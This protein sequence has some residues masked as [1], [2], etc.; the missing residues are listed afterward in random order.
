MDNDF[1]TLDGQPVQNASVIRYLSSLLN[2]RGRRGQQVRLQYIKGHSGDPGN[3]GADAQANIGATLPPRPELD[4]SAMQSRANDLIESLIP[5][6]TSEVSVSSTVEAQLELSE[7]SERPKKMPKNHAI[8]TQN[9]PIASHIPTHIS[10]PVAQVTPILPNRSPLRSIKI[11]DSSLDRPTIYSR[12]PHP[13]LSTPES[14]AVPVM[15]PPMLESSFLAQSPSTPVRRS[16]ETP[17]VTRTP[18]SAK[19]Y[20]QNNHTRTSEV[21]RLPP[22]PKSPLKVSQVAP[23]LIPVSMSDVDLDV[24]SISC[25][26]ALEPLLK[27]GSTSCIG[28]AY[29]KAKIGSERLNRYSHFYNINSLFFCI[30]NLLMDLVT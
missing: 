30:Y 2:E 10:V 19:T 9:S 28:I 18:T 25:Q 21:F 5:N 7:T 24:S 12:S 23:P 22:P 11:S 1:K 15:Q 6:Q 17:D 13:E 26:E 3:D 29:L 20:S 8:V 16:S 4:W 14:S 27:I